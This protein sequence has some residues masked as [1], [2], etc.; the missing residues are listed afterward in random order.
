[1]NKATIYILVKFLVDIT[2]FSLG[3]WPGMESL[4]N[5]VGICLALIDSVSCANLHLTM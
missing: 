1:M 5:I 2:L 4:D 3:L